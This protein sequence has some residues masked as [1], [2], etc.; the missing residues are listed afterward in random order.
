MEAT[1]GDGSERATDWSPL[2]ETDMSA[3][4][5]YTLSVRVVGC[6]VEMNPTKVSPKSESMRT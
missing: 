4:I 2:S 6:Q 3:G 5:S 1:V